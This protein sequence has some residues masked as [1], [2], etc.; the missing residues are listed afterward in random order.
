MSLQNV[1]YCNEQLLSELIAAINSSSDELYP[2]A[3]TGDARQTIGMHT[4]HIIEFYQCFFSGL[5][6]RHINYDNRTREQRLERISSVG[7]GALK[8][9]I[10]QL[11]ELSTSELKHQKLMLTSVTDTQGTSVAIES[12]PERELLF[13]HSH[14]THHMA[15][16]NL[17][18]QQAGQT[19]NNELG[20]ATSTQIYRNSKLVSS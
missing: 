19:L 12:S 6:S 9:I 8:Q 7:I 3:I 14:T 4:R 1:C 5:N 16:I 18:L 10:D 17:L 11:A 2:A 15:I 13:L 20:V